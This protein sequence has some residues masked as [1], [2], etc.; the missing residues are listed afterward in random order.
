MQDDTQWLRQYRRDRSEAALSALVD[1]HFNMVYGAALRMVGGD[2]HLARDV[3]QLVFIYLARNAWRL[4]G[5]VVLAAWLHRHTCFTASSVVRAERRR[6]TREQIAMEIG[7]MSNSPEP[8]WEAVAPQIDAALDQLDEA[9]RHA[10][11]LRFLKQQ[12]FRTLGAALGV[13]DD[14]AQ[15]RV[16]R[17]LE[18]LRVILGRRGV[19]LSSTALAMLLTEHAAVAAPAGIAL[20]VTTAAVAASIK[21]GILP[22]LFKIM[23][24]THVKTGLVAII[25][26]AS[27]VVPLTVQRQAQA[28]LSERDVV[29]RQREGQLS[30]LQAENL[31]LARQVEQARN[32][33]K[34][35]DGELNEVLKLRNE[36]GQLLANVHTMD[37]A[38]QTPQE[39]LEARKQYHA[40]LLA[41]LKNY[42]ETHPEASIPELKKIREDDWLRATQDNDLDTD[43]LIA[44]ATANLR[45]NAEHQ[46][47]FDPMF[48]ALRRYMKEN[49]GQFPSDFEQLTP[50]LKAPIDPDIVARYEIVPATSL[51]PELR[52]GED[53]AI[54]QK[55]PVD[56]AFDSRM[57]MGYNQIKHADERQTNRWTFQP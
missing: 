44:R 56:P 49:N 24:A 7:T 57:A 33:V 6:K 2:A 10:I 25:L 29:L 28:A 55:A 42:F 14:A 37:P 4:P 9:D 22:T 17:A 54:T 36:A 23:A 35:P 41:R 34:M 15:K 16:T 52:P 46:V 21:P 31:S 12:D 38:Q 32:S 11:V 47:F 26:A 50:Y 45:I 48:G 5:D 40:A 13:S 1:R 27:V 51:I 30:S 18:K 3:A 43:A 39:R 20:S 53:W 8:E 19:A